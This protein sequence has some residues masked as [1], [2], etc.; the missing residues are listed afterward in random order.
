[1]AGLAPHH[2]TD[3]PWIVAWLDAVRQRRSLASEAFRATAGLTGVH[4]RVEPIN[5]DAER[6]G[7]RGAD[8]QADVESTLR[9]GG[10]AVHA[11]SALFASVPGTPVLH[12]TS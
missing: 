9:E 6:D 4:V 1:V 12:S 2:A 5:A 3:G 10:L 11:Q 8:L 7:L